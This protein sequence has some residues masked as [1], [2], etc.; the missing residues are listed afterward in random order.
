[1]DASKYKRQTPLRRLPLTELSRL[2]GFFRGRRRLLLFFVVLGVWIGLPRRHI[3]FEGFTVAEYL[4]RMNG[5][6][7]E[8][9]I[10]EGFGMGALEDLT[11]IIRRSARVEHFFLRLPERVYIKVENAPWHDRTSWAAAR[12]SVWLVS[13]HRRGD[14]VLSALLREKDRDS[15]RA[16]LRAAGEE[17][18]FAAGGQTTNALLAE[19]ADELML[20]IPLSPST[21]KWWSAPGAFLNGTQVVI[22]PKG[23]T[24]VSVTR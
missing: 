7:P 6:G 5:T 10:V 2:I 19:I 13:L 3:R 1:M 21:P 4:N 15:I 18:V 8:G 23:A 17:A 12:A 22:T 9:R 14:P 11:G 20:D 24:N 16:L